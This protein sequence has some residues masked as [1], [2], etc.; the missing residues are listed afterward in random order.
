MES[1]QR[2]ES[3]R[4]QLGKGDDPD[5][6]KVRRG[7]IGGYVDYLSPADLAYC[8]AALEQLWCPLS[9]IDR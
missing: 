3:S 5:S 8:D 6:R 4:M 9:G 7:V 1:Q 2:F